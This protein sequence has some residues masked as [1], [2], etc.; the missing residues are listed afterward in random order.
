MSTTDEALLSWRTQKARGKRERRL[1]LTAWAFALAAVVAACGDVF[2][3]MA[4]RTAAADAVHWQNAAKKRNLEVLAAEQ[5][6]RELQKDLDEEKERADRLKKAFDE[7]T[8]AYAEDL[9]RLA[10]IDEQLEASGFDSVA[11]VIA[12]ERSCGVHLGSCR[13]WLG[14]CPGGFWRPEVQR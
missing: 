4:H 7:Q 13:A 3:A 8:L 5:R 12:A 9:E 11:D 6:R 2:F 10:G 14:G 1:K